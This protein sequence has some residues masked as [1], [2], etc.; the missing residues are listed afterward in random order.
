MA[1]WSFKTRYVTYSDKRRYNSN[2]EIREYDSLLK[3]HGIKK[4]N[5]T[6]RR[7]L[8]L[9]RRAK[10]GGI[11]A[12]NELVKSCL[13]L[14]IWRVMYHWDPDKM[15]LIQWG[16]IGL[17]HAAKK[18]DPKFKSKFST[19]AIWW[20][21]N[22]IHRYAFRS[23]LNISRR[24]SKW[25]DKYISYSENFRVEN[26]RLPTIEET[27]TEFGLDEV[28][29][30]TIVEC[31]AAYHV[32]SLFVSSK[33]RHYVYEPAQNNDFE[34]FM[35]RAENIAR[36]R[37][38]LTRIPE[39]SAMILQRRAKGETLQAI[40]NDLGVTKERIRQLEYKAIDLLANQFG[41]LKAKMGMAQAL[42]DSS[43]L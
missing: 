36:V 37:E 20:I 2:A 27:A 8:S 18:Y 14:V 32:Q 12:R 5:L 28:Q 26:G 10:A 23:I 22:Y 24:Y 4:E 39:R 1:R 43:P 25:V 40:A 42:A 33:S 34:L 38:A 9:G 3:S 7:S 11:R 16:N 30:E 13:Y 15:D 6:L 41:K 17:L 35:Q 29:A 21:D 19:Y 31:V